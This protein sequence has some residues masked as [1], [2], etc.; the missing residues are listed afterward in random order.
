MLTKERIDRQVSGQS[1]ATT[2]FMKVGDVH[3][4]N[5][6][7]V[8]FSTQNHIR[9]QLDKLV[10]MVYNMSMQKEGNNRSFKPQINQRERDTRTDKISETETEIDHSVGIE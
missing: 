2:P 4:S 10:S 9:E 7:K 3:H 6:K 1:G 5:R 8:S